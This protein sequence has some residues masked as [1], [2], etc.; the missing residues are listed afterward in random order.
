MML[1]S[2]FETKKLDGT[3]VQC[4]ING[5]GMKSSKGMRGGKEAAKKIKTTTK[6]FYTAADAVFFLRNK[7][8]KWYFGSTDWYFGSTK[9]YFG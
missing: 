4:N 5:E 1:Y 7:E 3:P 9:W 6:E 2:F 8:T